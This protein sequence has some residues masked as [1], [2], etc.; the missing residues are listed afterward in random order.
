MIY[1]KNMATTLSRTKRARK[2][3]F[4]KLA[5]EQKFDPELRAY[6][7]KIVRQFIIFFST[8]GLPLPLNTFE[9]DT[10]DLLSKHYTRV[11]K[12]FVTE[13]RDAILT[14]PDGALKSMGLLVKE[15]SLL[16]D[17]QSEIILLASAVFIARSIESQSALLDKTTNKNIQDSIDKASQ[18]LIQSGEPFTAANLNAEATFIL[19]SK[20]AARETTIVM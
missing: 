19:G 2:N 18:N 17:E 7:K 10:K 13:A 15:E 6:F 4:L 11:A 12:A 20:L 3:L 9:N 14:K 5:L 16:T 1:G 8:T